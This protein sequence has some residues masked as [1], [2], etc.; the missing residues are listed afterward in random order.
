L[1]DLMSVSF[2]TF[3]N[4][5][6]RWTINGAYLG[7]F[8]GADHYSGE[9]TNAS[10]AELGADT[11]Q[12]LHMARAGVSYLL[13]APTSRNGLENKWVANFNFYQ[14]VAGLNV[15]EGSQAALELQAF[16]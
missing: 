9:S 16:F 13:G 3:Y 11:A 4:L 10:Y 6:R 2:E 14:P 7:F 5:A 1:G 15:S 12:Q 8:K